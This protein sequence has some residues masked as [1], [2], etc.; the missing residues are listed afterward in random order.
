MTGNALI[1]LAISII[2]I[3]LLVALARVIFPRAGAAAISEKAVRDRLAFDEPDFQI[4]ALLLDAP[5]G[6]ALALGKTDDIALVKKAGDG[7]VTRRAHRGQLQC[8]R[9]GAQLRL[10]I[11]DHSFRSFAINADSDAEAQHWAVRI[12]GEGAI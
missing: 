10:G 4:E 3:A 1:D 2:G 8:D 9:D 7:L 12:A 5:H 6:A 11:S